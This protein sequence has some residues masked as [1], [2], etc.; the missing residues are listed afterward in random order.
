MWR[1]FQ[2]IFIFHT[3][4]T[5]IYDKRNRLNPRINSLNNKLSLRY[6]VFGII[7]FIRMGLVKCKTFLCMGIIHYSVYLMEDGPYYRNE[8]EKI[9]K[10]YIPENKRLI[11]LIG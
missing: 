11:N 4:I 7:I 5:Y 6:T 10:T 1:T 9:H 8:K 3:M 2:Y